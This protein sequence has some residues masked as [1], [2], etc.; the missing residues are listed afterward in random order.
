MSDSGSS[1]G[2]GNYGGVSSDIFHISDMVQNFNTFAF[3]KSNAV[4][5]PRIPGLFL[6]LL[7]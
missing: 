3:M 4:H 6:N 5:I 1:Y 2:Y 7:P